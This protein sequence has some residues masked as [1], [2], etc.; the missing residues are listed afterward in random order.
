MN[1]VKKGDLFEKKVFDYFQ[2][3]INE[4]RFYAKKE[5]C[6]IYSKKGYYSKDRL[7]DIIFDIA[8]EIYLPGQKKY[9]MLIIIE[10]KSYTHKV[11]V[12]DIEELYAKV[13]QVSGAKAILVSSNSFQEGTFN[14]ANSKSIGL[15]RYR[16]V[17]DLDWELTRSPSSLVS[18]KYSEEN[19]HNVSYSLRTE[20]YKNNYFDCYAFFKV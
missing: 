1:T 15:L 14:F 4:D 3:E 7:K 20:E 11:P 6:R 8:I 18:Y 2:T 19:E 9:S 10:C 5:F 16:S 12:D 13:Q 17:S